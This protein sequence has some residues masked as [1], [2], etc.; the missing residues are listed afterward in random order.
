MLPWCNTARW[1]IHCGAAYALIYR[2][3][4]KTRQWSENPNQFSP[5]PQSHADVRSPALMKH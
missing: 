2:F 3:E 1:D 5:I 4:C